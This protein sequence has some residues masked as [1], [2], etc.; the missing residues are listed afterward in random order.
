MPKT[1]IPGT[2]ETAEVSI[3]R[4]DNSEILLVEYL[5][6]NRMGM[7]GIPGGRI[8]FESPQEVAAREVSYDL[9]IKVTL[10]ELKSFPNNFLT[11]DIERRGVVRHASVRGYIL[12]REVVEELPENT[13]DGK[14][15]SVWMSVGDLKEMKNIMPNTNEMIKAI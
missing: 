1:E 14:L 13:E 9:G 7:L 15:R 3:F 4:N 10:D 12:N 11:G 2:L 5:Q 8:E 6:G